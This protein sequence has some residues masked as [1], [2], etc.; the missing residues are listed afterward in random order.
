MKTTPDRTTLVKY[1]TNRNSFTPYQ[2][3][4][5]ALELSRLP[6]GSIDVENFQ[7]RCDLAFEVLVKLHARIAELGKEFLTSNIG[8]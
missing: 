6:D 8:T 7:A 5:L 4:G 3:T 2:V 1:E